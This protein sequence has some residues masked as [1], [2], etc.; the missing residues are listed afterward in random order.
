MAAHVYS[1]KPKGAESR[2]LVL[3]SSKSAATNFVHRD[4]E[5]ER[6]TSAEVVD[7]MRGGEMIHNA[8]PP[9]VDPNQQELEGV[10]VIP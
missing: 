9:D 5:N 2:T 6:L 7:A 1:V 10:N 8:N 3:A 4:T